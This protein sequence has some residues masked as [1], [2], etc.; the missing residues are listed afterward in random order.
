MRASISCKT[1][2]EEEDADTTDGGVSINSKRGFNHKHA[3][4]TAQSERATFYDPAMPR[5]DATASEIA[6][7]MTIL[8]EEIS[9]TAIANL[10]LDPN[11]VTL[12]RSHA[13]WRGE[14]TGKL[15]K[16]HRSVSQGGCSSRVAKNRSTR[17][18]QTVVVHSNRLSASKALLATPQ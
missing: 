7:S 8:C 4:L 2:S 13:R 10:A 14:R 18:S 15:T 1:P 6:A 16:D 9:C 3:Y 11:P 12:D 5:F 17:L